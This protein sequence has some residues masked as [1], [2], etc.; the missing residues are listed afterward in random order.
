M[1]G[2]ALASTAGAIDAFPGA[3]GFGAS[4]TGGR[5]GDVYHVTQLGDSG[6]GSLRDA[7][8]TA[9]G[10]RTIVFEVSG[11]IDL[12]SPL[13]ISASDLTIAGQ[14]SPAGIGTRGPG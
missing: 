2:L 11:T 10:P 13:A 9:L 7:I 8:A 1:G 4:A 12:A 14:T 5:G 6:P 3:M